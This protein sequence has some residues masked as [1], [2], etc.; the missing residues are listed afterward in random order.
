MTRN[1]WI[2]SFYD[3]GDLD[4][5]QED[6][7]ITNAYPFF[8]VVD[9]YSEPSSPSH[10]KIRFSD[11]QTGG[12]MVRDAILMAITVSSYSCASLKQDLLSVNLEI[13]ER[14]RRESLSSEIENNFSSGAAFLVGKINQSTDTVEIVQGGDCTAIVVDKFGEITT[15]WGERFHPIEADLR[16]RK[17]E[18]MAMPGVAGDQARM[19][20]IFYPY[21]CKSRKER[22]NNIYPILDGRPELMDLI[23]IKTFPLSKTQR[24][25]CF[26]D[27]MLP[28][29]EK[30]D[31]EQLSSWVFHTLSNLNG[32]S[33]I[34]QFTRCQEK[35]SHEIF[36]AEA[37]CQ[38]VHFGRLTLGPEKNW[39]LLFER[40]PR[41]K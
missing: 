38:V 15:I 14:K 36:F 6:G 17:A 37:S 3:P 29:D 40:L 23:E 5:I 39:A 32:F 21:L 7:I 10:P 22:G 27:G 4:R 18:I 24:I 11:G 2:E 19:E 35:K 25:I 13:L 26:T 1:I 12:Q 31:W 16:R 20:E 41:E 30:P 34:M 8:G 28:W 33:W 9:G